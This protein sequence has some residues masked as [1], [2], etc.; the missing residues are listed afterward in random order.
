M[1]EKKKEEA[2][3]EEK[4]IKGQPGESEEK[5]REKEEDQLRRERIKKIKELIERGEYYVSPEEIAEKMLK[6][7]KKNNS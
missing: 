2:L 6:F 5:N 4:K 7:F 3:E 1:D